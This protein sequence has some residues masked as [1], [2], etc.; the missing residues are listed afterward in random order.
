MLLVLWWGSC[1]AARASHW[2]GADLTYA[3]AGTAALPNQYRITV[4]LFL[5]A[6]AVVQDTDIL[7]TCGK[8][9]CGTAQAGSFTTHLIRTAEVTLSQGCATSGASGG[10]YYR[11]TTLEGLVQLPP[12]DWTLS[13]NGENRRSGLVN[14]AKSEMQSIYVK[15]ELHNA[16]GLINS[17]PRFTTAELIQL[18]GLQARSFSLNAYD[19]EGDSLVYQ[20]VQPLAAPTTSPGCGAATAGPIAPHFQINAATGQLLTGS[21]QATQGIYALAVRIDEYR[22]IS[23]SWQQIGSITR[24]MDYWVVLSNN[25]LPAFTRVARTGSPGSQLL[26][27]TIRVNAGQTLSLTVTATDAD[28]GQVLALSSHVPA[29]FPGATFQDLGNGQGLLTWQVPATQPLGR[30]ALTAT[31]T[32][33]ACPVPGAEVLTVPVVV[34]QQLLAIRPARQPLAQPPYPSPFQDEVRFQ[35]A[36]PGRQPVLISD[37]LGRTVAQLLTAADGSLVWHP[38]PA[39]AAGL[40]LARNQSGSQVARLSYAGR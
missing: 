38:G 12:A 7:L 5:D 36:Q 27:Q 6:N 17:S 14:M 24:D 19:N 32:D 20:L 31:A 30:Y 18:S 39:V 16:T 9:G 2:L 1:L 28:A 35:L 13:I 23:G 10:I 37:E 21:G 22:R 11:V 15:A 3:Y 4:R 33:N 26:G 25:Q 40:Y 29:V 34:I 8:N